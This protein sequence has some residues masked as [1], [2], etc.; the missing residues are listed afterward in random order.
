MEATNTSTELTPQQQ[1]L[2]KA[3]SSA[4]KKFELTIAETEKLV[5]QCN[6]ITIVDSTTLAL[7]N[8]LLSK[9]NLAFKDTEEKR[10]SFTRPQQDYI[11]FVNDLIKTK[12]AGPLKKAVDEGKEKLR[13]WNE[14]VT[15]EANAKKEE[16]SRR[17]TFLKTCEAN[18]KKQVELVDS[19]EKAD[20]LIGIINKQWPSDDKFGNYLNEALT[21]KNNFIALLNTKKIALKGAM[22]ND[23]SVV[24]ESLNQSSEILSA[25][26]EVDIAVI[27]KKEVLQ[28]SFVAE[29]SKV[30]R[31]WKWEIVS[32]NQLPREFL[33]IDKKKVDEYMKANKEKFEESGTVKGG[34]KFFRDYTPQIK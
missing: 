12:I 18:M 23:V 34:V 29:T 30:R 3:K 6:A 15:K 33:S 7:S 13:L 22:S 10:K 26:E 31:E 32:E 20:N 11:D 5:Q 9:A 14:Q 27:E 8:Q 17:Y 28:E 4:E 19:P 2:L 1:Q 25:Q 21:T 16:D 24:S